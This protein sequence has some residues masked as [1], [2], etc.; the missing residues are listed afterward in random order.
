LRSFESHSEENLKEL[1]RRDR[2]QADTW[3]EKGNGP[4]T[5]GKKEKKQFILELY[6]SCYFF[7]VI[8]LIDRKIRSG[9]KDAAQ[10]LTDE[11][12]WVPLAPVHLFL[13]FV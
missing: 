1:L 8:S 12:Y 10:M 7:L 13:P 3:S 11:S 9:C 2:S 5:R 6:L 4:L